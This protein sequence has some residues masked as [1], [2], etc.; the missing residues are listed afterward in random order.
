MEIPLRMQRLPK[1]SRGY[2]VPYIILEKNGKHYFQIN[3]SNKVENA[4]KNRLCAICAMKMHPEKMWLVGGPQSAFHEYGVYID[5]PTHYECLNYAMQVCPYLAY[6]AYSKRLEVDKLDLREFDDMMLFQDPTQSGDKVPFF[7]CVQINGFTMV[8][9]DPATRY[10]KPYRP[11]LKI[12]YWTD[13][14]QITEKRA[15]QILIEKNAGYSVE[16]SRFLKG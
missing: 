3:D 16:S 4:I 12:E 6:T 14:E 7:T 10:V 15:N 5:T 13:G 2:P 9:P 1:D 8:R 11:Y